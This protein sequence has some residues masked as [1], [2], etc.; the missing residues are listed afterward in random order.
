[1]LADDLRNLQAP[2]KT[3]YREQPESAR[4]T[5][6]ARGVLGLDQL[7]CT[8]QAIPRPAAMGLHPAAGGDGNAGCAAE[9]LLEALVGCAGVTL[10]AVATAMQI[11]IRGGSITAEGDVDFRGTLGID[12]QTP[13]GFTGIRLSYDLDAD[14]TAEQLATLYKLTERYCVV[15]QTLLHPPRVVVSNQA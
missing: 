8:L 1:M 12:R 4:L 15:Y 3:R 14:A 5:L 10:T 13:V 2:F 9:T 7:T 6:K 11:P